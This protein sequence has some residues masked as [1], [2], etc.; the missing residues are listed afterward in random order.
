MSTAFNTRLERLEG[1]IASGALQ[2]FAYG[3]GSKEELD[4]LMEAAPGLP[5]DAIASV[6]WF[7]WGAPL[8]IEWGPAGSFW[9]G[10]RGRWP[11]H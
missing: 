5:P 8:R 9:G 7:P 11:A 1:Q 10:A 6:V 4:R 2:V 3:S